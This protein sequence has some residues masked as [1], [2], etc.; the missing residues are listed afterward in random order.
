VRTAELRMR[1]SGT[2]M[3]R[4][5]GTPLYALEFRNNGPGG[6]SGFLKRY[7][8]SRTQTYSFSGPF[9]ILSSHFCWSSV[10]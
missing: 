8:V 2:L 5:S 4:C 3:K 1:P 6:F 7:F 9:I 10:G